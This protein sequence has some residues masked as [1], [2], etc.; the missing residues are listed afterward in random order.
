MRPRKK[1]RHLPKCMQFKHNAY[2]Y[3]KNGTWERLSADYATA[4]GEYAQRVNVSSGGM[5]DLI[6]KVLAHIEPT[7]APSTFA[8]YRLA[9]TRLSEILAEFAPEQVRPKH[10]AQIKVHFSAT[11]NMAN[12]ILSFLRTVFS[13]AV[14]WQIVEMNPCI[15]IRRHKENKR[16]RLMTDEEFSRI[17]TAAN[18]RAIPAIMHLCVLTG[19]RI[20]DILSLRND[21]ITDEGIAFTQKKTGKKLIVRMN[22]DL[23]AAIALAREKH[24]RK[25]GRTGT[26]ETLLYTRGGKPYS[27]ST[28]KCAFDRSRKAAGIPDVTLHDLRAKSGTDA[29]EQGIDPQKLLGHTTAQQTQRYLRS[30]KG[31]VVEGPQRHKLTS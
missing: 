12:R 1:D 28:I 10:V 21:Q 25:I 4:L 11:P 6:H 2:Y 7:L 16:T 26:Y 30:K 20:G 27:Y 29:E 15:G 17:S 31:K 14:E 22:A 19:Q 9:A 24:P 3:V 23:K 18:H 13:Y 5:T 8:Q